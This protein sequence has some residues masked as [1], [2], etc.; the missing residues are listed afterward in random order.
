MTLPANTRYFALDTETT[1]VNDDDKVVE[2]GWIELDADFNVLNQF[3]TL[4]DP[5]RRIAPA[6]S[7]VHGLVY[8][9]VENSPTIEEYFSEDDPTCYGRKIDDPIVL[10]GHRIAFDHKFVKPYITNVVQ[11]LCTLRWARR[12]YPESDNHQLQ[13]LVYALGLPRA[14]EAHRV[15]S[16]VWTAIHLCKHICERTGMTLPQL[17]EASAAPM[18]VHTM[19]FGKHKGEK[20]QDIPMQYLR[21]MLDKLS[22]DGDMQFSVENAIQYKKSNK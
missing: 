7:A 11:E 13:T 14:T 5:Q 16:D 19:S 12:L 22:L 21:W 9:D 17:A 20:I 18:E 10:I 6:A 8:E 4:L 2:L 1:G 3:E 15:M